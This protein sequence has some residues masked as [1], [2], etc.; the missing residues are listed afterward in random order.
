[1]KI[2]KKGF[3]LIELMIVVIIIGVLASIALPRFSMII[4]KNRQ[5]EAINILTKMYRGCKVTI[6][7]EVLVPYPGQ[8]YYKFY[9]L[10]QPP[11]SP[12]EIRKM[13]NPDES[14]TYPNNPEGRSA[15]SWSALGFGQNP[16]HENSNLYFSYDFLSPQTGGGLNPNDYFSVGDSGDGRSPPGERPYKNQPPYNDMNMGVAWRKTDNSYGNYNQYPIDSSKWIF[17]DMDTGK[18]YKSEYY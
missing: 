9:N 3:T 17:I 12:P 11:Y 4:E 7:D 2:K 15:I 14:D 16:N 1:M 10:T 6:I 18:I 5:T 13:F 8:N